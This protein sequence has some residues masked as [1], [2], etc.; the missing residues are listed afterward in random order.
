M[1]VNGENACDL[2]KYLRANSELKRDPL[3]G[4]RV[5][6]GKVYAKEVT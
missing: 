1:N 3:R 6:K 5:E 2:Y 4:Q